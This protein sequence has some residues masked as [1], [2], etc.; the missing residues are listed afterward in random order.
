MNASVCQ[1]FAAPAKLFL[2]F[3]Q[4]LEKIKQP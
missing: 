4:A 1:G 3:A 2:D